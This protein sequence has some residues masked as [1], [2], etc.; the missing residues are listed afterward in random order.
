[1]KDTDS[2]ILSQDYEEI[3]SITFR[4]KKQDSEK[5]EDG[6]KNLYR[7]KLHYLKTL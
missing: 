6:L 2:K 7:T 1:L 3:N 5:L 4:I